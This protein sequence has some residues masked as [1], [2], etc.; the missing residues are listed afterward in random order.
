[1]TNQRLNKQKLSNTT[2]TL[3]Y[4]RRTTLLCIGKTA[5]IF[6]MLC[7]CLSLQAKNIITGTVIDETTQSLEQL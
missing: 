5:F 4:I 7:L 6:C 2:S 3:L 1:M